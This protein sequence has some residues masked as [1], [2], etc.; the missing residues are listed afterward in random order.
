MDGTRKFATALSLAGGATKAK[1]RKLKGRRWKYPLSLELQYGTAINRYMTKRWK[2][3]AAQALA[4][5]VPRMDAVSLEP[6]PGEYGPALGAIV[7]IARN[8]GEFNKREMDAFR[9]I[10]VGDAFVQDEPWVEKTLQDWAQN[11]VSLITKATDDM[12]DAVARRVR[13]GVKHGKI[14]REIESQIMQD[15]P[16]I[17]KRRAQIIARDQAS[18]LNAALSEGRMKDAGLETYIWETAYDER[19]RG[20]PGGKYPKALPSHWAMQGKIC[21]WDDPTVYRNAK[22]EWEKRPANCPYTTPGTEILCRCVALPNWD[23]LEEVEAAGPEVKAQLEIERAQE[24]I[25]KAA[26]AAGYI[27]PSNPALA[28]FVQ[29]EARA[30]TALE[31]LLAVVTGAAKKPA[32]VAVVA[33]PKP[34]KK[35]KAPPTLENLE[36][37]I[38]KADKNWKH[39]NADERARY[40][41]KLVE[42]F[43]NSDFGMNV[44][45]TNDRGDDVIAAI[46]GS[47]FKNQ[48]ETKT[49]EGL[50]DVAYRKR[51]SETLFGTKLAKTKDAEFEKYGFL[52]DK[53]M[54]KQ[55]TSGI[56]DQ[57]WRYGDGV[58]VRFKK[59][60][61]KTTFTIGDSLEAGLTP[62]YTS[63]PKVVSS[64]N[65]HI[66]R[67]LAL[68]E[69][70]SAAEATRSLGTSYIELQYHGDLTP[71]MVESVFI[72]APTANK[73]SAEAIQKMRDSGAAL[74]THDAK[75]NVI[76]F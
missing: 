28:A 57:Y 3:Y 73:L 52:M 32:A 5:M 63:D 39:W 58:Q 2:E 7:S 59:D 35:E 54:Y 72:P 4:M 30:K 68:T 61:V 14:N 62:S 69:T 18:K 66:N 17:S 44:P 49:G 38:K 31:N 33:K 56:A 53:D 70:K 20:L 9:K 25:E 1:I 46:F 67:V 12:R 41:E 75:G 34:K 43:E 50:V 76:P 42:L 21:R 19:V 27:N 55:A 60:M 64:R 26:T 23:E 6:A 51:A 22:G 47:H 16:G 36:A 13:D 29:E 74:Y 8:I 40:A 48:M 65:A 71:D 10:A 15:L 37:T 24:A 45:R 11:Q